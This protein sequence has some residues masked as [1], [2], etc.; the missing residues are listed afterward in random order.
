MKLEGCLG[1]IH[2]GIDHCVF[3][4]HSVIN[5][6]THPYLYEL[7]GL[8]AALATVRVW[9]IRH[10]RL[11]LGYGLARGRPRVARARA[12]RRSPFAQGCRP[13]VL[14]CARKA[15]YPKECSNQMKRR[16]QRAPRVSGRRLPCSFSLRCSTPARYARLRGTAQ[17]EALPCRCRTQGE[18]EYKRMPRIHIRAHIRVARGALPWAERC[19]PFGIGSCLVC[20]M[21][22]LQGRPPVCPTPEQLQNLLLTLRWATRGSYMRGDA[23]ASAGQGQLGI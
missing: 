5:V 4:L 20:R 23:V 15:K 3:G 9:S 16:P 13:H 19:N 11:W 6:L 1:D 18:P 10:A 17:R 22:K 12:R 14:A 8:A 7:T 2:P 21:S